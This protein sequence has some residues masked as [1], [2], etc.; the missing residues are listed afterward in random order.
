VT[1]AIPARAEQAKVISDKLPLVEIATVALVALTLGAYFRAPGPPLLGLLAVALA[2]LIAERAIAAVGKAIG[3]SVPSEVQPVIVVLLFGVLTDYTIFY[4]SRYRRRLRDGLAPRDAAATA[5]AQMTPT[6]VAAALAVILA[7]STLVAA[8]L[9]FLQAF[10]PGVAMSVF[11]GLAVAVTFVPAAMAIAAGGLFWPVRA[12]RPVPAS[13]SDVEDPTAQP[14]P[15]RGRRAVGIAVAHPK[16]TVAACL[17][18]LVGCASGLARLQPG[19]GLIRGLPSDSEPVRAYRAA[20]QGFTPGLLSPTTVVVEAP[21]IAAQRAQ[22]ADLQR[23]L[24]AFGDV[25][26]VAGPANNPLPADFGATLSFTGDAARYVV[27]FRSDPL[28]AGAIRRV[29]VLHDRLPGMLAAAGLPD[30]TASIAGDTALAAETVDRTLS[31]GLRV[32]PLLLAALYIVLAIFLRA[33]V[34]PL[35]MLLASALVVAAAL[36]LTV[37]VIQDLSWGEITYYVPFAAAVLLIALGS[38]YTMF[39]AGRVWEAARTRPL[40]EA[41]VEGSS[42]A[43]T[44]IA[45][46]GGLLAA[47]FALLVLVPLRPFRELAFVMGAGL[48]LDAFLVRPLLLPAMLSLVGER[49]AWPS[50]RL[51]FTRRRT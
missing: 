35:L 13:R 9:G 12:A 23:R 18:L 27:V 28:G 43:A 21:G 29:G 37:Y 15:A 51:T 4:V 14:H 8:Q 47:S 16:L 48:V 39:L 3:I 34:A 5:C 25:A 31:D 40:R 46:A 36:G 10:G 1:G 44:A 30:A 50:R 20:S 26:A 2:Y 33:L 22:L 32:L 42:R 45:V 19:N 11:V 24:A 17:L 49:S 38:D 6:V 41:I 7:G